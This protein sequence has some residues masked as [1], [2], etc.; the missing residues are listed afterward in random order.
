MFQRTAFSS[1][2][3]LVLLIS[4]A[5]QAQQSD[6][7]NA[8]PATP[9]LTTTNAATAS[10][11]GNL[12]LLIDARKRYTAKDD[13]GSLKDLQQVLAADP[14]NIDAYMLRGAIYTRKK[15]WPQAQADFNAALQLHPE[16]M[17]AKYNVAEVQFMQKNYDAARPQFVAL[18]GNSE[19]GD[20]GTYKVFLCDLLGGHEDVAAKELEVMNQKAEN[21]SY[22]FSNAAWSLYH[23]NIEDGRSWLT[24]ALHIYPAAKNN[25]YAL[26]LQDLG[27]LPLPPPPAAK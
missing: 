2:A 20:I 25:F 10:P 14:K 26:T 21:P 3:F 13:D 19:V 18:L 17:I 22:F 16:N 23:K 1:F 5:V 11:T 12:A 6:S 7:T 15:Q 9:D 24:S 4:P 8:T 27:Y